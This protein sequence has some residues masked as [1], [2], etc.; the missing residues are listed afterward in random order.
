MANETKNINPNQQQSQIAQGVQ[1]AEAF[2]QELKAQA[3]QAHANNDVFMMG[4]FRELLG[5]ASPIVS[6]A[7]ARYH[8]EERAGINKMHKELRAKFREDAA[9]PHLQREP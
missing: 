9:R 3:R 4:L 2:L 7:I 6:K 1:R 8:R 5:V